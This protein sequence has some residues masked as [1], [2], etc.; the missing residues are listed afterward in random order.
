MYFKCPTSEPKTDL[1]RGG[2]HRARRFS[3]HKVVLK[4]GKAYERFT[5]LVQFSASYSL[6]VVRVDLDSNMKLTI[7]RNISTGSCKK[8]GQV[9][10]GV[11]V[12]NRRGVS[13]GLVSGGGRFPIDGESMAVFFIEMMFLQP[14]R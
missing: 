4:P 10:T 7:M 9:F 5:R 13:L 8:P 3:P 11:G 2:N 6:Q 1:S 14:T 12:F